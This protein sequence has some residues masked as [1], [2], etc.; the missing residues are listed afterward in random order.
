MRGGT[1]HAVAHRL[2]AE[3]APQLGL[4]EVSVLDAGD[5]VDLL[6]LLRDEHGLVGSQVGLPTSRVLADVYTRAVNIGRPTREVIEGEFPWC[7][8][9]VDQ[10]NALLGDFVAR[11]RARGMLDFDDLLLT[12]RALLADPAVGARLRAR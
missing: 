8:D 3:H 7:L 11:K 5:V 6:D 10:I 2:M 4:G 9:H 1:F 12:W